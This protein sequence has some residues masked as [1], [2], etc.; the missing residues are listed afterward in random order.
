MKD[1]LRIGF[2]RSAEAV[3]RYYAMM[4]EAAVAA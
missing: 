4:A 3:E 1:S 2:P